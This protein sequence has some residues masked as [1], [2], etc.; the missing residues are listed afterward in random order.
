MPA[1]YWRSCSLQKRKGYFVLGPS[2]R[3]RVLANSG[4]T[5]P[6]PELAGSYRVETIPPRQASLMQSLLQNMRSEPHAFAPPL[7]AAASGVL[8]L[9][10]RQ[11]NQGFN[12][13]EMARKRTPTVSR[14]RSCPD[15]GRLRP[16]PFPHTVW[17]S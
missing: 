1:N 3:A 11:V 17:T 10:P 2:S 12:K 16:T 14:N 5:G 7:H 8:L 4:H 6:D 9:P 13:S 15:S